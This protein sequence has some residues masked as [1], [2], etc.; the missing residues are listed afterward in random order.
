MRDQVP[1][2]NQ[3]NIT[4]MCDMNEE[5]S[6]GKSW[7]EFICNADDIKRFAEIFKVSEKHMAVC[8][9]L[10][11][12]R[13]YYPALSNAC[14]IVNRGIVCGGDRFE[15]DFYKTILKLET[16]VGSYDDN[17]VPIPTEAFAIY[18]ILNPKDTFKA[19]ATSMPKCAE[20]ISDGREIPNAYK[21]FR[22]EL[23]NTVSRHNKY[24]QIDIDTKDYSNILDLDSFFESLQFTPLLTV[25]TH[26]GF[27]IVYDTASPNIK[28]LHKR[29]YEFRQ[30]TQFTKPS[31]DGKMVKDYWFSITKEAMVI[32]PG[33]FQGGFQT[34]IISIRDW[35]HDNTP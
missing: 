32:L 15:K 9:Y 25:E 3:A 6:Q 26:G 18:V 20:T 17:D 34:R 19:L 5:K 22:T 2:L 33:T 4:T 27:H 11:A 31:S 29:F 7:H 23:P 28:E 13:K 30:T 12:R 35:V 21:V 1:L 14:L 16:P 10:T 8:T 24:K